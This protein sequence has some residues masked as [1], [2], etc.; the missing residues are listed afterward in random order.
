MQNPRRLRRPAVR[1][2][3]VRENE[4]SVQVHSGAVDIWTGRQ[5]A[6]TEALRPH[7]SLLYSTPSF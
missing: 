2:E 4:T 1:G 5:M 3:L 6:A 7:A